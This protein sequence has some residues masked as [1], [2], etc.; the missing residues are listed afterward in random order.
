MKCV[1][2]LRRVGTSS[3][4]LW[5]HR[6][7]FGSQLFARRRLCHSA[8]SKQCEN[9]RRCDTKR[10]QVCVLSVRQQP[11]QAGP[12][13]SLPLFLF[14]WR[15]DDAQ[16]QARARFQSTPLKVGVGYKGSAEV[17]Q[18]D[19]PLARDFPDC[20]LNCLQE[21]TVTFLFCKFGPN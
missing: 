14:F 8:V 19:G 20:L 21:Q 6:F 13:G 1:L 16:S 10:H 18:Q 11:C 5:V 9:V 3:G 15:A 17:L 7:V 12:S 2:F 4:G